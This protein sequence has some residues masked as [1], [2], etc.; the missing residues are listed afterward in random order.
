MKKII[1]VRKSIWS[2]N[3]YDVKIFFDNKL[4]DCEMC[5]S[6]KEAFKNI[7]NL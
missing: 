7:N 6:K 3:M 4:I 1:E 5:V 2:K